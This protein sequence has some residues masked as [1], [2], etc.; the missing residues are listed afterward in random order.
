MGEVAAAIGDLSPEQIEYLSTG[1]ELELA[2]TTITGSDLVI[3]R[4]SAPGTLVASAGHANCRLRHRHRCR[5]SRRKAWPENW[6][7]G[8]SSLRREA[9]LA[10]SDRIEV[11]WSTDDERLVEAISEHAR[12]HQG[13]SSGEHPPP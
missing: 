5:V 12:L 3:Q 4:N 6:S 7:A 2:G 13:R 8:S 11:V 10:V 9:G 1:G